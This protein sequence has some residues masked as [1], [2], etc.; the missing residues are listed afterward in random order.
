MEEKLKQHN[1]LN[2]IRDVSLEIFNHSPRK[3]T[4]YWHNY[5]GELVR[6]AT[7]QPRAVYNITTFE[8]HP[9]SAA[10]CDTGDRLLIDNEFVFYPR[11]SEPHENE[12]TT[13]SRVQICLP[14]K[15]SVCCIFFLFV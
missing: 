13:V 3:V 4:L 5:T 11:Q 12:G 2:A 14:G 7:L 6:Y 9:W 15:S 1:S 10:D 8:T